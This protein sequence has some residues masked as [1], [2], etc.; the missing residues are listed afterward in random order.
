M[1]ILYGETSIH[2]FSGDQGKKTIKINTSKWQL[3]EGVKT[4]QKHTKKKKGIKV[5][6]FLLKHTN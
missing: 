6:D 4:C 5:L 3:W 2:H 1:F